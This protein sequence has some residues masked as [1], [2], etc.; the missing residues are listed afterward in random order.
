[1]KIRSTV[2]WPEREVM[3][4]DIIDTAAEGAKCTEAEAKERIAAGLAVEH[5]DAPI[6]AEAEAK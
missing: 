6:E 5:V 3:A 2:F 4:N 1:M